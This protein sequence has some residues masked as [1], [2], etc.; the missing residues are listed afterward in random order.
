MIQL[1]RYIPKT[2]VGEKM[3]LLIDKIKLQ[4]LLEK[5]RDNIRS[6][7]EGWDLILTGVL[8]LISILC[9]EYKSVF[10]L[11]SETIT[12]LATVFGIFITLWGVVKVFKSFRLRYDHK[13]L[14]SDIE[15][16]NEILHRFS[17]VALKDDFNKYSN[18][19]LLHY[20][21]NWN[22]W[23]FF[24]FPTSDSANE[25]QIKNRMSNILKVDKNLIHLVHKSE[26]LQPKYSIKDSVNKVY[27]H[28]L[29]Q[30]VMGAFSPEM[31]EDCFVLDGVSYKWMTIAEMEADDRIMEINKDVVSF[32]KEKIE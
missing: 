10:G 12:V 16:L 28:S 17:I 8:F 13:L 26:R 21:T 7:V 1:S 15:N 9:S 30:A 32:V 27:Q 20:D 2:Y 23:F 29:Y 6:K 31:E 22:C 19:F 3:K 18:R 25:E 24:S 5:K 11:S 4:L 14:F